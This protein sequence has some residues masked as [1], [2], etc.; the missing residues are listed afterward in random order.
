MLHRCVNV[1]F[2][3]AAQCY[4]YKCLSE[5]TRILNLFVTN[6]LSHPHHLDESILI[7]GASGVFFSFISF[8]N[9]IPVSKLF[10]PRFDVSFCNVSSGC[11]NVCL[12]PK[13]RRPGSYGLKWESVILPL[14][15]F[16]VCLYG[17]GTCF[18]IN[19]FRTN[20]I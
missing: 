1:M 6:E 9:A 20:Q 10:S 11:S 13:Q 2:Y 8:F 12:C 4:V 15:N 17:S 16:T 18:I 3:F 5:L 14:V 7:L 19:K